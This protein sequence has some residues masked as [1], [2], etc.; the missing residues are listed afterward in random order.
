MLPT[1]YVAGFVDPEVSNRPDLFDVY[2]N[3][4]ERVIQVSQNAKGTVSVYLAGW[5]PFSQISP[6]HFYA[7]APCTI[8]EA[9]AM[10]KL[11]K[12]IGHLIMQSAEDPDRSESQVIM[13]RDPKCPC[14]HMYR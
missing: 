10:G 5:L 11:H 7:T 8:I 12:D 4:P 13:V 9:M 3:L 14:I 2:V 6:L 1:G